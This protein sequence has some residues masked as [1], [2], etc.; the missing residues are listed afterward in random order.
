MVQ[1]SRHK[2]ITSNFI[3]WTKPPRLPQDVS[4]WHDPSKNSKPKNLSLFLYSV[5]SWYQMNRLAKKAQQE[6]GVVRDWKLDHSSVSI[7]VN[8]RSAPI[9]SSKRVRESKEG[10]LYLPSKKMNKWNICLILYHTHKNS[11]QIFDHKS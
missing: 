2:Q 4:L 8:G 3:F 9:N 11:S 6:L 10:P 5:N 1:V 7:V